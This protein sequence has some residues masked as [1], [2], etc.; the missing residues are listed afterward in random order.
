[1]TRG[2]ARPKRPASAQQVDALKHR[3]LSSTI[4]TKKE[5]SLRMKLN[6]C[7]AQAANC[8]YSKPLKRHS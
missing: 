4:R 6:I 1:M 7:G 3:G 8:L 2:L 5:I